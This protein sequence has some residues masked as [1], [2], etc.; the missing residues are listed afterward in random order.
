[1]SELVDRLNRIASDIAEDLGLEIVRLNL[2]GS[3]RKSLLRIFIDKKGGVTIGD[4]ENFSRRME[5]ILDVE[6]LIKTSYVL[7]VSSPGINRPLKTIE[8]FQKNIGRLIRVVTKEKMENQ[9]FFIGKLVET[10]E[11]WIR[12]LLQ[13]KK[14]EKYLFIPLEKISKAQLEIDLKQEL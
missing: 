3:G 7:E 1:M 8:D 12:L 13:G 14:S 4:C 6:D 10:S 5:A 11:D 2:S 9:N